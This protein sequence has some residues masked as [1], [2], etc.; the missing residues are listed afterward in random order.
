[1][2]KHY[3]INRNEQSNGDHEVHH[4]DCYWLP[5]VENRSYLGYFSSSHEAVRD[6]VYKFPGWKVNGCYY[7]CPESH[8]S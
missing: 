5:D 4:T 1:M 6:A 2:Y 7:C 3:Y 8:T